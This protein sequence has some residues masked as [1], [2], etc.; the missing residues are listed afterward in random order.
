M[1]AMSALIVLNALLGGCLSESSRGAFDPANPATFTFLLVS[2]TGLTHPCF[3]H[4]LGRKGPTV[5]FRGWCW[6]SI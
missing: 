5:G 6:N 3:R 4:P 1:H 2:R